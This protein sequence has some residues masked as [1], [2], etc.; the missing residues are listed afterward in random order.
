M[1]R[2]IAP[3]LPKKVALVW[4]FDKGKNG[5]ALCISS[6][7]LIKVLLRKQSPIEK[8]MEV[9][10]F[11]VQI[12]VLEVSKNQDIAKPMFWRSWRAK[13]LSKSICS[14]YRRSIHCRY[15]CVGGLGVQKQCQNQCF[16]GLGGPAPYEKTMCWT[17]RRAKTL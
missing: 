14:R 8:Y 16:G 5:H 11:F 1:N 17:S 4:W 9:S 3:L 7:T 15:R 13:P 2:V 10:F 12:Y 6:T